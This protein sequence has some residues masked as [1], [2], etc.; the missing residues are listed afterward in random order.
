MKKL[1]YLFAASLFL[2]SCGGNDRKN[3]RSENDDQGTHMEDM[4][5]ADFHKKHIA[6]LN[7][8]MNVMMNDF[9]NQKFSGDAD[10]DFALVMKRHHQGALDMAQCLIDNGSDSEMKAFATKI[11]DRQLHDI[12]EFD[13]IIQGMSN[14]KGDSDFGKRAIGMTTPMNELKALGTLDKTYASMMVSHHLDA[15]KIAEEYL[16]ESGKHPKMME[17]ATEITK[18]HPEEIRELESFR[19]K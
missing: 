5:D 4:H 12:Q 1:L 17:I 9:R 6:D 8:A 13:L 16:K 18:N 2:L 10:Y 15:I 11:R 3:N 14:S 7:D 19:N